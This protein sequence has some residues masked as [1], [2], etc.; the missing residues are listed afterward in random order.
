MKTTF[1]K[2]ANKCRQVSSTPSTSTSAKNRKKNLSVEERAET[3]ANLEK[4]IREE[5]IHHRVL[6]KCSFFMRK[7]K[8][9]LKTILSKVS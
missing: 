2:D 7:R 5:L 9:M 1:L 6:Q 8:S 4:E 3:E